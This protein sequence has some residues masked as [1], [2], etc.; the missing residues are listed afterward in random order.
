M[1]EDHRVF[2]NRLAKNTTFGGITSIN[3]LGETFGC[4]VNIY[5][6]NVKLLYSYE[7]ETIDKVLNFILRGQHYDFIVEIK[8]REREEPK[9][10]KTEEP[11][12]K[13][14]DQLRKVS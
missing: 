2:L 5:G 4:Q 14:L 9:I 6:Q 1:D 3:C 12:I 10:E 13:K 11:E 8:K 7:P